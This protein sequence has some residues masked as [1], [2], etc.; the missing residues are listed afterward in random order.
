MPCFMMIGIVAGHRRMIS[1]IDKSGSNI[2]WL[3]PMGAAPRMMSSM[4]QAAA[5]LVV[6]QQTAPRFS[7]ATIAADTHDGEG[8]CGLISVKVGM[9]QP[10]EYRREPVE[11]VMGEVGRQSTPVRT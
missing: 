7:R 5:P 3:R 2:W 9:V 10:L 6:R 8:A 1:S 4:P 11:D